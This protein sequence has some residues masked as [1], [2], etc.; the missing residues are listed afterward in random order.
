MNQESLSQGE[1]N[2]FGNILTIMAHR[3]GEFL[4]RPLVACTAHQLER[5]DARLQFS[6]HNSCFIKYPEMKNVELED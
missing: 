5:N 2:P 3:V 1:A 6:A 4:V